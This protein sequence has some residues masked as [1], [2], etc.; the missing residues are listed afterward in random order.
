MNHQEQPISSPTEEARLKQLN[1]LLDKAKIFSSFIAEQIQTENYKSGTK[2]A[3]AQKTQ[4]YPKPAICVGG[5]LRDYQLEGL[6][7][8]IQ[9]FENGMNGI[10]ADE[11]G[12]GKTVVTLSFLAHLWEKGIRGPFLVVAPLST[13]SNW[14]NEFQKW[15]PTIPL[16][17]YHGNKT[18]RETI[19]SKLNLSKSKVQEFPIFITSYD[20]AINDR[21]YLQTYLWKCLV[22][23]EAHR[24]KN[25]N[26]KL[27]KELRVLKTENRLL[28]TGTPLQNNLSEL[29]SLLNF[30]LPDIFDSVE[31]FQSWF[32]FSNLSHDDD[33]A[34]SQNPLRHLVSKLHCI[35]EPFLLRRL[36][37]DVDIDVPPKR[38]IVL[39]CPFSDHQKA[40]YDLLITR[41]KDLI[42]S[43]VKLRLL[44]ILMQLRKVCNHPYLLEKEFTWFLHRRD[45]PIKETDM[46]GSKENIFLIGDNDRKR[47]AEDGLGQ[48]R[49]T[50]K[51]C[52]SNDVEP[53]NVRSNTESQK[54]VR[55]RSAFMFFRKEKFSA[56]NGQK[57][58][59]EL[60]K[61]VADEWKKLDPDKKKNYVDMAVMDKQR[62]LEELKDQ[63]SQ[64]EPDMLVTDPEAYL[65]ELKFNCGK[66]QILDKML[67]S[68]KSD[69][70]KV[71]IFSQMT[72]MLDILEDYLDYS[73]YLYCRIDGTTK[74]KDR[75][76]LINSFNNDPDTFC[77]LLSTRAGGLGINLTA[78][79]TV[80]IYD[81]DWNPQMDLQAQDRCHR[82]GQSKPVC[83][84]RLITAN[85]IESQILKRANQK[86][87]LERLVIHKE[88]F[89]GKNSKLVTE[90]EILD[91]LKQ[92]ST[93]Q[94]NEKIISDQ[95][96]KLMLNRK[97]CIDMFDERIKSTSGQKVEGLKVC[98]EVT[99]INDDPAEGFLFLEEKLAEF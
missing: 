86:L 66:L 74:Q 15:C 21:K 76:S 56:N 61:S 48:R 53:M 51:I 44:N 2:S 47:K 37:I 10:L 43:N 7:W 14:R 97:L 26:C 49:P 58:F 99:D 20:I 90:D 12:L 71:L 84:Y 96:L 19:R 42:L 88:R 16:L 50:R 93:A 92:A 46:E 54:V 17:F 27:I 13:L 78:A 24:L 85:S 3:K 34:P 63:M 80:I 9:L 57:N 87:T 40:F 83:V 45:D 75:E 4:K 25:F 33:S 35:L 67:T 39:Y 81:S 94:K 8:L 59:S 91:I 6:N 28:L 41:D 11:M 32:D 82:I 77:F 65:E 18:E 55:N 95:K 1:L 52:K 68:L 69:G 70:H 62:Y 64:S 72:R 89:K 22:V 73:G 30:I 98:K 5:N 38:E 36:K 60:T 29:W 31:N 79:D 23:D